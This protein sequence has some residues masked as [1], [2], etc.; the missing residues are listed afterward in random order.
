VTW[1]FSDKFFLILPLQ[2][3][4]IIQKFLLVDIAHEI[5]IFNIIFS[6]LFTKPI[7]AIR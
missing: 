1:S 6:T 3:E 7:S 5:D 2:N 4:P